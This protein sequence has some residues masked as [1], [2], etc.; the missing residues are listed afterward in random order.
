MVVTI[1][2]PS[3]VKLTGNDLNFFGA[4]SKKYQ[5]SA[6]KCFIKK[7][8]NPTEIKIYPPDMDESKIDF[9]N[10]PIFDLPEFRMTFVTQHP[11]FTIK[12]KVVFNPLYSNTRTLKLLCD[13]MKNNVISGNLQKSVRKAEL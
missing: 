11:E 10:P 9:E 12:V 3:N 5:P 8:N 7:G 4:F 2:Y 13:Q 1:K 6:G